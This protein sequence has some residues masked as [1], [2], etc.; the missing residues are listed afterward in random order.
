[1]EINSSCSESDEDTRSIA[2]SNTIKTSSSNLNENINKSNK[3]FGSRLPKFYFFNKKG[4]CFCF[5]KKLIYNKKVRLKYFL[6][7]SSFCF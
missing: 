3:Q 2:I 5:Y 1:M 6:I 4:E 7:K